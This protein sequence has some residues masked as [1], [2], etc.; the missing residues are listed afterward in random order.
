MENYKV[1]LLFSII[2]GFI[3]LQTYLIQIIFNKVIIPKFPSS[4]I[5][6]LSFWDALAI[7]VL[8]ALLSSS[9][10]IVNFNYE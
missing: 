1:I 9:Q 5:K 10:N 8:A 2:I 3:A 6:D 7:S 4:N